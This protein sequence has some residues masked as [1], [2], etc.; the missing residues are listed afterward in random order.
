[1]FSIVVWQFFL[2]ASPCSQKAFFSSLCC[3]FPSMFPL[4][5][6]SQGSY[7][8]HCLCVFLLSYRRRKAGILPSLEDLLFYTIAEGQEKIPAHKFT[9]VSPQSRKRHWGFMFEMTSFNKIKIVSARITN[10]KQKNGPMLWDLV[11]QLNSRLAVNQHY[12]L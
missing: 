7:F 8:S 4:Q 5:Q 2:T 11:W 10:V 1:M 9:T 12:S 6:V 3:S